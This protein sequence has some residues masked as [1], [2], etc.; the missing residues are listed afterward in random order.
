MKKLDQVIQQALQSSVPEDRKII[1]NELIGY[2]QNKRN[3]GATPLLHFICTHNSRR[4]QFCQVWSEVAANYF[5][6]PIKSFSGGTETTEVNIR[7]IDSLHRFGF[8]II[9]NNS[10]INPYYSIYYS[11][12]ENPI[13]CFSKL[14]I[15]PTNPTEGFAAIMTCSDADENCPVVVGCEK[16]IPLRYEDPKEYDNMELESIMYD[17]LSLQVAGEMF[18]VFSKVK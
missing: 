17:E 4:S 2:I 3:N 15:D 11:E 10:K 5:K 7:V 8:E 12:N 18:Y 16:R 13:F 6:I 14:I 1:L 9:S